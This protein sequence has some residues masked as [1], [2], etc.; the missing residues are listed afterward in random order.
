M[1]AE[2]DKYH[3]GSSSWS[4]QF[5]DAMNMGGD[6]EEPEWDDYLLHFLSFYWKVFH[7]LVPPTDYYG[8]WATFWVS[9]LFIG[10]ITVLVG[11][12]AKMLGCVIG[13][14]DGITAI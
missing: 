7:A 3:V 5:M 12:I 1:D 8:G 2:M 6:D 14:E 11:D 10:A 4:E 9:L 13:L